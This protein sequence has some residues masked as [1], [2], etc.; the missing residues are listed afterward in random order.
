M[1]VHFGGVAALK[2][3]GL[4][5]QAGTV[6]GLIGPNGA[7]KT[8]LFNVIT[9]LQPA[10]SGRILVD[11]SDVTLLGPHERAR[12]GIART[13]QRLETFGTLSVRDNVLV[14]AE[15]RHSG[16][17]K[18]R[19]A[20]AETDLL[21]ER[22]GLTSHADTRVD[23]LPTG[24]GRLVEVARALALE[25][26]VLLMDEGSS[27]LND[28]E[29]AELGALLLELAV[30]GLAVLLVEHDVGF[31]MEH[32]GE[33]TVLDFGVVIATG[34]PNE[35]RNNELVRAAYLGTDKSSKADE[36][37]S[38]TAT[39]GPAPSELGELVA[40]DPGS[41]KALRPREDLKTESGDLAA[42]CALRLEHITAGYGAIDVVTDF[43]LQVPTGQ[44]VALLGPNGAGKSTVLKAASGEI[45][46]SEGKVM[47][48]EGDVTGWSSDRL[49]RRGMCLI[50][51]G[52]G[53]FPNLTVADNLRMASFA[54]VPVETV[55]E[56]AVAQ[57]PRLG[58]YMGRTAGTLSG[59]EQQMLAVAR[60]L[61]TEPTMLMLDELSM[62][63]API[64]VET[65]YESVKQIAA[66]GVSILIVEQF[67]DAVLEI[68]NSA[69]IMLHGK[70][71][72]QGSPADV[73]AALS[74]SYLGSSN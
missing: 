2:G 52:R 39:N 33:I 26:R 38:G 53:V 44:V 66:S 68:A 49:A 1:S 28:A 5:L 23:T 70:I 24:I 47:L 72:F 60:A 63:L 10:S 3:A 73:D 42:T 58:E 18:R 74:E 65:L 34:T 54:R 71:T 46:T 22:V 61:A 35:V 69:L 43:S 12:L 20:R 8:T 67:A 29:T 45:T 27:G 55:K 50:P 51:E 4:D 59:G 16:L 11:G 14:A 64:V 37:P 15:L 56:R 21:L 40:I 41:I 31:V 19:V 30:D 7:G 62:G 48:H 9:G 57:F 17:R 32:C 25:P 13:F 36:H 6:A